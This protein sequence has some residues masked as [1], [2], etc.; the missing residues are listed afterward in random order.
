MKHVRLLPLSFLLLVL[1]AC[2]SSVPVQSAATPKP[3]P[4]PGITPTPTIPNVPACPVR[5]FTSGHVQLS[6]L[7]FGHG[8]TMVICSHMVRTSKDIWVESGI[9]QRLAVLGYQVLAYDF[10]GYG[11]SA[12]S[13]DASTLDVDLC[14]AEDF[15]H[16]Q[17]ATKIVL[18]GA[19]TG[20]TAS[21]KVAAGEQVTAVL[22]LSGPQEFCVSVSDDE[23]KAIKAP[24]LFLA[25][26]EDDSFVTDAR[27]MYAIAVPPK[28]STSI[29]GLTTA[30]A[31]STATTAMTPLS[32]CCTSSHNTRRRARNVPCITIPCSP[33]RDRPLVHQEE[34]IGGESPVAYLSLRVEKK[35]T[36]ALEVVE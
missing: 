5:F 9:P 32:A 6:G 35:G 16:Q 2:G 7:L 10:R 30:L 3:T 13:A 28:R 27:H 24:K 20:G 21:L 11:D 15:A 31:S 23:V 4:T 1:V 26:E 12:G 17:G 33:G 19:S 29:P 14:A 25:S 34:S 36:E 22:S 8:K 18:L